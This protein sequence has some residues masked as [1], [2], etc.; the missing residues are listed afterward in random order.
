MSWW[1]QNPGRAVRRVLLGLL[2]T[3]VATIIGLMTYSGLRKRLRV[4]RQGL[5]HIA[6]RKPARW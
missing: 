3:Q 1:R 6:A 2:Y 4:V 5:P